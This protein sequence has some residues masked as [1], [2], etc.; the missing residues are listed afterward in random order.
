MGRRD[1]LHVTEGLPCS[2][3]AMVPR[4][5]NTEF[6]GKWIGDLLSPETPGCQGKGGGLQRDDL[7]CDGNFLPSNGSPGVAHPPPPPLGEIRGC[8]R[9]QLSRENTGNSRR[10]KRCSPVL[11]GPGTISRREDVCDF[12]VIAVFPGDSAL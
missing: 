9:E 12:I 11:T 3:D 10:E 4:S 2:L 7:Y 6:G 5:L 1:S 8:S